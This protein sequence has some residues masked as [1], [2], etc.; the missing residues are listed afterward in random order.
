MHTILKKHKKTL[1]NTINP[2]GISTVTYGTASRL[3]SPWSASKVFWSTLVQDPNLFWFYSV[4]KQLTSLPTSQVS[5][6]EWNAAIWSALLGWK[7]WSQRPEHSWWILMEQK[8]RGK[9]SLSTLNISMPVSTHSSKAVKSKWNALVY[10][11]STCALPRM[12]RECLLAYSVQFNCIFIK[13]RKLNMI[14]IFSVTNC[15]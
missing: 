2:F 9:K 3:S 6:S 10:K 13:T 15:M 1:Q 7:L 4:R 14:C 12:T 11:T 5:Y 8:R